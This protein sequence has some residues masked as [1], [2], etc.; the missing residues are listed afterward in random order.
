MAA[1]A[2]LDFSIVL[3]FNSQNG[4]GGRTAPARQILWKSVELRPKYGDFSIFQDVDRRRP[5]LPEIGVQSDAPLQK[6]PISKVFV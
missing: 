3:I 5:H 4:Q 2:M 6:T 1:A